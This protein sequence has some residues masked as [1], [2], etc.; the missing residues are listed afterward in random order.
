MRIR[1]VKPEYWKDARLHNTPGITADVREF[2]IGTW[3]L[4]D[5]T[6]WLR[7]DIPAIGAELYAYRPARTREHNIAQWSERLVKLRR[8]VIGDCGHAFVPKLSQH[9]RIGGNKT[10]HI[11]REHQR[12]ALPQ[13]VRTDTDKDGQ[14]RT[15]GEVKGGEGKEREV[16]FSNDLTNI[17]DPTL[18]ARLLAKVTKP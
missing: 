14:V 18:R 10:D 6:G 13:S 15:G 12:C 8:L 11:A 4:A 5:D 16:D 1:S 3:G 7:W 9:Q 17:T 2:Y